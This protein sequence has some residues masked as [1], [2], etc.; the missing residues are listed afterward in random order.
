MGND[1]SA[2]QTFQDGQTYPAST[3]NSAIN[4][5]T[6]KNGFLSAK[7][8]RS[9]VAASDLTLISDAAG[10]A[11][12]SLP[13]SVLKSSFN[14]STSDG[15]GIYTTGAIT[16][17]TTS[18]VVASATGITAGM[19]VGGY[20]IPVGATVVSIV[21]LTVT[22]SAAA[23]QTLATGTPVCFFN[24]VTSMNTPGISAGI[25][26]QV[27]SAIVS[28]SNPKY[29]KAWVNFTGTATPTVQDSYNVSSVT[30]VS[31]GI[32]TINFSSPL[33]NANYSIAVSTTSLIVLGSCR[34]PANRI[35]TSV[36]LNFARVDTSVVYD[37]AEAFVQIFGN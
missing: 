22:L 34:S 37:P 10:A 5:A 2:G 29:A 12:S 32:Y 23:T 9:S 13:I 21:G 8:A 25:V 6:I 35:T 19:V 16:N 4:D 11:L 17:G 1:I 30:R 7:T 27:A 24:A 31:T 28:A 33:G 36:M 14:A 18:L 26:N 3:F 15:T 20:G